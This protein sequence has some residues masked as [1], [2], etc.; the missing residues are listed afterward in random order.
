M[1]TQQRIEVS[2]EGE[3]VKIVA[4]SSSFTL[5]YETAFVLS[6]LMAHFGQEAKR[7]SGDLGKRFRTMGVVHDAEKGPDAGQPFTPNK[8]YPVARDVLKRSSIRV[9][10]DANRLV[11]VHFGSAKL[12]LPYQVALT[13]AQWI[14]VRA[15]E[16][17]NR[18]GD[19]RHWSVVPSADAIAE[20]L[21][22]S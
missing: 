18:A 3:H 15:K 20:G 19:V 22:L 6:Y 12:G 11:A 17:K 4:G 14:R 10:L 13:I 21:K 7:L 1:L 8:V 5:H 16:S 9:D 2:S